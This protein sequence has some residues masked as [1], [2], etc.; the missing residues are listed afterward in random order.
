M[1]SVDQSSAAKARSNVV[2]GKPSGDQRLPLYQLLRDDLASK[3][4]AGTW[5][6]GVPL[7]SEAS[8][9]ESYG[10]SL[11]TMRH[12][13]EELVDEGMLERRQGSGTFLRRPDFSSSM[14]RF[15]L[16]QTA[17]GGN[18][19]PESRILSRASVD[20]TVE[21]AGALQLAPGDKTIRMSRLRLYD[22]EPFATEEIWLPYDRFRAFYNLPL[23][24]IGPLLYPVYED[25]CGQLVATVEEI[26]T[27]ATADDQ[28]ARLL[29]I[30]PGAPVAMIDRLARAHNG[31]RL[32]WRRSFGRGDRFNYKIEIR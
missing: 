19:L 9:A 8:L 2:S 10:V 32:E 12:A 26:L 11:G 24:E 17:D 13:I 14:F 27:I 3:I 31:D 6:L 28:Q 29:N 20:P 25:V 22:N 16:F 23:T 1:S 7:P 5:R 15:F 21:V 30:P 4:S 18:M